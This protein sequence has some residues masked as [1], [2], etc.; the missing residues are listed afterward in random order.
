MELCS[1]VCLTSFSNRYR[2]LHSGGPRLR[3]VMLT[4]RI[5]HIGDMA[6]FEC[7]GRIVRRDATLK[8]REAVTAQQNVR[9]VL[10]DLTK[11]G[12]I[13]AGG[14]GMLWFLQRWTDDHDIQFKLYNPIHSV[15]D[16]LEHN[17]AMLR[18]DIITFEEMMTL[19]AYADNQYTRAA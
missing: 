7:K 2:V 19:V 17:N 5:E 16:R 12:A 11:V 6:I 1:C 13:E 3:S 4:L 9:I 10:L 8:L 14:L 18:F 15:R